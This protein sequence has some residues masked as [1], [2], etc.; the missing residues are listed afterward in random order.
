MHASGNFFSAAPLPSLDLS[1]CIQVREERQKEFWLLVDELEKCFDGFGVNALNTVS[2]VAEDAF[3]SPLSALRA[4]MAIGLRALKATTSAELTRRWSS[5]GSIGRRYPIFPLWLG[6]LF[7][8][9]AVLKALRLAA[10]PSLSRCCPSIL[11]I[12]VLN[13]PPTGITLDQGQYSRLGLHEQDHD[14]DQEQEQDRGE[15][16]TRKHAQEYAPI[17]RIS[18]ALPS[19]LAPEAY[20][21]YAFATLHRSHAALDHILLKQACF[22]HLIVRLLAV[23]EAKEYNE[24]QNDF[25]T[26]V[27]V[28]MLSWLASPLSTFT[29]V[30]AIAAT[31]AT[32]AFCGLIA[33]LFSTLVSN[34]RAICS[35][36]VSTHRMIRW[37]HIK[38][39]IV[40]PPL[41]SSTLTPEIFDLT[42]EDDLIL[43][44]IR[45][46]VMTAQSQNVKNI[47]T[48]RR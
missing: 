29:H 27:E 4:A 48:T 39:G 2:D 41:S 22:D 12:S 13:E 5:V 46:R 16:Q 28:T 23:Y 38:P 32:S 44:K 34:K 30:L 43:T 24:I 11:A 21:G 40:G 42:P 7:P 8:T 17:V 45:A 10:L 19:F 9:W 35:G 14:H 26:W 15:K 31:S 37:S 1:F 33:E 3:L 6:H 47:K 36:R 18:P 25:P 20:R